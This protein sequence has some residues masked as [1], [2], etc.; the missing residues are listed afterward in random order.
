[1]GFLDP[2]VTNS[3]HDISNEGSKIFLNRVNKLAKHGNF[4]ANY[5]LLIVW[6]S[7][8]LSFDLGH[9]SSVPSISKDV[10]ALLHFC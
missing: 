5:P 1:M 2:E 6:N 8:F 10:L 3:H 9:K 4:W 7:V